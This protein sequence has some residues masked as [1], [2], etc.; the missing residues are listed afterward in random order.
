M[1]QDPGQFPQPPHQPAPPKKTNPAIIAIV[2]VV[3]G[4]VAMVILGA[5]VVLAGAGFATYRLRAAPPP[6]MIGAPAR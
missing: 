2:V 5:L 6:T 3:G 1:A 4:L